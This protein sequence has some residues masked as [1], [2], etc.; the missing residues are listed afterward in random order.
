MPEPDDDARLRNRSGAAQL[1]HDDDCGGN[2][3]RRGG[4]QRDAKL[5]VVSIAGRGVYVRNLKH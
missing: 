5:A 4:M 3:C 1:H 2:R